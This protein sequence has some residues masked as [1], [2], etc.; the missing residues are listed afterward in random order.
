MKKMSGGTKSR[1]KPSV[2][3]SKRRQR[4]GSL[5]V[6]LNQDPRNWSRYSGR[7]GNPGVGLPGRPNAVISSVTNASWVQIRLSHNNRTVIVN[8][9]G[10]TAGFNGRL[11]AGDWVAIAGVTQGNAPAAISITVGWTA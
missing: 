3:K 8:P 11:V 4:R 1:A 2:L 7:S 5:I 6:I 9:R 10:R